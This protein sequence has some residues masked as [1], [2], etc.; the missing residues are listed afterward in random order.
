[1]KGIGNELPKNATTG[2]WSDVGR[3]ALDRVR[4]SKSHTRVRGSSSNICAGAT[5]SDVH[6]RGAASNIDAGPADGRSYTHTNAYTAHVNI[7]APDANTRTSDADVGT[8]YPDACSRADDLYD[9]L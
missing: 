7:G 8:T 1:M 5:G 2:N 4:R 3:V 9:C 6:T